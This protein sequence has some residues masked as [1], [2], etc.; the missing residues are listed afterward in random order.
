MLKGP[1]G[2]VDVLVYSFFTFSSRW[3]WVDKATSRALRPY[4]RDLVPIL[5]G[6][7]WTSGPV[8]TGA[9]N[10][11]PSVIRQSTPYYS[12]YTD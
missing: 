7:G 2:K 9:K 8:W 5:K 12:R 3:V 1:T 6:G 10:L 4:E 11:D